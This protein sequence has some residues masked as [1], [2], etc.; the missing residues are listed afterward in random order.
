MTLNDY[1]REPKH[2]WTNKNWLEYAWVQVH[3]PWINEED[4]ECYRDMIKRLS[5]TQ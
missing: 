2:G 4:R 5:N 1:I 3:N